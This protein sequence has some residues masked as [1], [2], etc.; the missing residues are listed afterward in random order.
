MKQFHYFCS[1]SLSLFKF[2]SISNLFSRSSIFL[3]TD[4][5]MAIIFGFAIIG[6][7]FFSA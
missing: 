1:A 7:N 4:D 2:Y 3:I 5:F 6:L